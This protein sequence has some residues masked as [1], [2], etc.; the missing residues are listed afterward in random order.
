MFQRYGQVG[1]EGVPHG[2]GVRVAFEPGDDAGR[3]RADVRLG[4][5]EL[6]SLTPQVGQE[7]GGRA[8]E[9]RGG[10][11][12]LRKRYGGAAVRAVGG[13]TRAGT[14]GGVSR[15]CGSGS[16]CGSGCG[17]GSGSGCAEITGAAASRGATRMAKKARSARILS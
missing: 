8:S 11:R 4:K 9:L 1:G 3:E 17:S 14:G 2:V 13:G 10:P 6:G 15:G 5:N 16:G 12:R 7:C